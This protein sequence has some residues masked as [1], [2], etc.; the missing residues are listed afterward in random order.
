MARP[1]EHFII[2][3]EMPND[4]SPSI[5]K[6]PAMNILKRSLRNLGLPA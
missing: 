4:L 5:I 3:T 6:G 2:A 1:A